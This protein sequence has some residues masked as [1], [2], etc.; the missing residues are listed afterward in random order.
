[1]TDNTPADTVPA[2]W[3]AR[4]V[5][6]GDQE[7]RISKLLTMEGL[8]AME[9]LRPAMLA[10]VDDNFGQA[11]LA[12]GA[13]AVSLGA[14]ISQTHIFLSTLLL[15]LPTASF[16]RLKD[17]LFRQVYFTSPTHPTPTP[18]FGNEPAAFKGLEPAHV[19]EMVVRSSIVNFTGSFSVFNSRLTSLAASLSPPDSLT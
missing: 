3:L 4:E 5:A 9:I 12:V 8:A 18:V 19:Y 10:E 16:Y 13:L 7:F 11:T 17:A 15:R 1:M 14:N 6:L 2:G